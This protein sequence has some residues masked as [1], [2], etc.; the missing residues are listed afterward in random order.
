MTVQAP[1]PR[2]KRRNPHVKR[3]PRLLISVE[4]AIPRMTRH[5]SALIIMLS[6][7]TFA[8]ARAP[9]GM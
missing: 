6:C 4:L 9:K 2:R 5:I 7:D 8:V 3:S 1:G